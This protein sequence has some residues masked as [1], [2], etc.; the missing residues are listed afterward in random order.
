LTGQCAGIKR[1]GSRCSASVPPG[2]EHCFNHDP[3][4]REERRRNA[5]RAGR[6]RPNKELVALK[7]QLQEIADGVLAGDL[8]PGRAAIAVQALNV[9][10]RALEQERRWRELGELEERIEQL[11]RIA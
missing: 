9:K 10:I 4:R 11:E 8:I 3:L 2:V 1:D 5:A 7:G 6:S